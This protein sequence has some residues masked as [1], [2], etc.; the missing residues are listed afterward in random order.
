MLACGWK[1]TYWP[2][3]SLAIQINFY[4]VPSVCSNNFNRDPLVLIRDRTAIIYP[5]PVWRRG[6][7]IH[8]I[9]FIPLAL[10]P[11]K[12]C[13][14]DSMILI[15]AIVRFLQVSKHQRVSPVKKEREASELFGKLGYCIEVCY[16]RCDTRCYR[17]L[18][19]YAIRF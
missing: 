2:C 19:W 6:N 1:A 12:P 3:L 14:P 13:D 17:D 15:L 11:D 7:I 5:S 10:S 18:D 16:S 9:T 8:A 4:S